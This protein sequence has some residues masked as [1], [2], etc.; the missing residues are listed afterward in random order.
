MSDDEYFD[1]MAIDVDKLKIREIEELEEITG[2]PIDALESDEA[3]K[4]KVLRALAYI[5]KRREDA[6]LTL[7]MAGEL[8]LK[9]SSDPKE[10]SDQTPS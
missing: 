6:D 9:P 7:E 5:Y 4:G 2:L 10:S 1:S 3:P 8:I